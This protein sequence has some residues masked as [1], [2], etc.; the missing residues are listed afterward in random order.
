[1][2][3]SEEKNMP[4]PRTVHGS[5]RIPATRGE[6]RAILGDLDDAKVL[7]ILDLNPTVLELEE[8]AVWSGGDGDI[9]GKEGRP[10]TGIT[11]QVFEILTRDEQEEER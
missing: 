6:L 7:E 11:A 2:S 1:V 4:N 8:A 9:L 10:L 5:R 3:V